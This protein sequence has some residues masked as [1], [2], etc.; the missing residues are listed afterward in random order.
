VGVLDEIK[1]VIGEK[2][3]KIY[4]KEFKG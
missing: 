3:Y 1:G 4:Y 2:E